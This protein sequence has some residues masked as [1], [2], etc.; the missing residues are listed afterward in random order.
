[1]ENGRKFCK[2]LDVEPAISINPY[3]E[4]NENDRKFCKTLDVEPAVNM[5]PYRELI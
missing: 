4:L 5:N 3:E 2:T 1:M